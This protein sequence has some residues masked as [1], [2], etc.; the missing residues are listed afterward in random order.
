MIPFFM[1]AF[2]TLF[3]VVFSLNGSALRDGI[4]LQGADEAVSQAL[5]KQNPQTPVPEYLLPSHRER[6]KPQI[7]FLRLMGNYGDTADPKFPIHHQM[8]QGEHQ[9]AHPQDPI[10]AL[11][12]TLYPSPDQDLFVANQAA[13]DPISDLTPQQL[14]T[15]LRIL[16]LKKF[17]T[18]VRD[19]CRRPRFPKDQLH[20]QLSDFLDIKPAATKKYDTYLQQERDNDFRKNISRDLLALR[21]LKFVNIL[22]EASDYQTTTDLSATMYVENSVEMAL[23]SYAWDKATSLDDLEV[24]YQAICD[25]TTFRLPKHLYGKAD[26]DGVYTLLSAST[27]VVETLDDLSDEEQ[28]LALHGN[29]HFDPY[30]FYFET[31]SQVSYKGKLYANCVEMAISNFFMS[32]ARVYDNTHGIV[33]DHTVFP[34]GSPAYQYFRDFSTMDKFLS[35]EGRQAWCDRMVEKPGVRY[36]K[37]LSPEGPSCFELYPGIQNILNIMLYMLGRDTEVVMASDPTQRLPWRELEKRLKETVASFSRDGFEVTL[38]TYSKPPYDESLKDYTGTLSVEVNQKEAFDWQVLRDHSY[39]TAGNSSQD[40]VK[41][42]KHYNNDVVSRIKSETV[43]PMR[44][45]QNLM[46]NR[47]NPYDYSQNVM[48][49]YA[50]QDWRHLI[51]LVNTSNTS[52]QI[53]L[54]LAK[55]EERFFPI[56][57]SQVSRL[58]RLNDFHADSGFVSHIGQT[59]R[60]TGKA[61]IERKM[62]KFIRRNPRLLYIEDPN[63]GMFFRKW[64][65]AQGRDDLLTMD[66]DLNWD[67]VSFSKRFYEEVVLEDNLLGKLRNVTYL[68]LEKDFVPDQAFFHWFSTSNVE[69]IG[70]NLHNNPNEHI[71]PDL[72]KH[73]PQS[74]KQFSV[75]VDAEYPQQEIDGVQTTVQKLN[76]ESVDKLIQKMHLIQETIPQATYWFALV[77]SYASIK[78]F[79]LRVKKE[80]LPYKSIDIS[81]I[82]ND[83]EEYRSKTP[84]EIREQTPRLLQQIYEELEAEEKEEAPA[85]DQQDS[86]D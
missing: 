29:R 16:R 62:E 68:D 59:M 54:I 33:L 18:I 27:T 5:L 86:S 11:I 8:L 12:Q 74:L 21:K 28:A 41:W 25:D 31:Y 32:M 49:K 20:K 4:F 71:T 69:R 66:V 53:I 85:A 44:W 24:F 63:E 6:T 35:R 58:H 37:K 2:F 47:Y 26:F 79:L 82:Y 77:S 48:L 9:F 17:N 43:V 64:A 39:L 50:P 73:A 51:P 7:R 13:I 1:K 61:Y 78:E 65:K 34:V 80:G 38:D 15:I 76:E 60:G 75:L 40:N 30:D 52:S 55:Q 57:C 83:N 46:F 10:A 67:F 45:V 19:S 14:G 36:V 23:V 70:G 3:F 22:S 81:S 84:D 56:V 72:L 42:K